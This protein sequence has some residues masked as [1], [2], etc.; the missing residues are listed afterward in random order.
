[1]RALLFSL[2]T[3]LIVGC[4]IVSVQKDGTREVRTF[5]ASVT[6]VKS[7]GS[8]KTESEGLSEGLTG[9]VVSIVKTAGDAFLAFFNRGS[10]PNPLVKE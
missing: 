9:S 3:F 6:T 2:L 10:V 7:D 4:I 1:M 5:G 8:I